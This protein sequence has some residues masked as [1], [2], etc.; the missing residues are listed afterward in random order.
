MVSEN[1][2]Y[3]IS[4]TPAGSS[5]YDQT[6]FRGCLLVASLWSIPDNLA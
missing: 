6:P 3:N 5:A 1:G 2:L 4:D